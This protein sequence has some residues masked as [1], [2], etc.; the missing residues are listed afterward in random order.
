MATLQEWLQPFPQPVRAAVYAAAPTTVVVGPESVAFGANPAAW[1]RW[2][3]ATVQQAVRA[4]G[5]PTRVAW[6]LDLGPRVE[7]SEPEARALF[8]TCQ[9]VDAVA[10]ATADGALRLVVLGHVRHDVAGLVL[11]VNEASHVGA[12]HAL[13]GLRVPIA[14]VLFAPRAIDAV[15]G[16]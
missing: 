7:L 2:M 8:G 16:D 14:L 3:F 13:S 5:P 10:S 12:V 1:M 11:T 15:R 4:S 9:S 6:L